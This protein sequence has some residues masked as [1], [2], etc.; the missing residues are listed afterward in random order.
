MKYIARSFEGKVSSKQILFIEMAELDKEA[1]LLKAE[2]VGGS[3]AC[4]ENV[5]SIILMLN[6][7][8]DSFG[9][10]RETLPGIKSRPEAE[11]VLQAFRFHGIGEAIIMMAVVNSV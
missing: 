10:E 2:K 6:R 11:F 5:E 3:T 9:L 4:L 8:S 7:K 1:H